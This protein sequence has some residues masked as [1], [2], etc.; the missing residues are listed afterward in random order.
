METN[1]VKGCVFC[2]IVA[3]RAK[4]H[5]IYEDDLSLAILDINPFS[6]GHTLVIPKRHVP[7]WHDLSEEEV[8]SLFLVAREVSSKIMRAYSPDF[9]AIY[10][11]GRRIPHT[12]IFVVPTY[13][14]DVLDRF[15]NA[16][17]GFQEGTAELA[18]LKEDAELAEAA[19][20]L[21]EA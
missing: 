18:K 14:G 20:R 17:E 9:V 10:A 7:W 3:G 6:E 15:F 13:R 11:R 19:D 16:L 12:H 5:R 8:E 1:E 2:D 21:K 4:A